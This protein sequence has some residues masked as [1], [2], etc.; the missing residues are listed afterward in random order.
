MIKK[1]LLIFILIIGYG[2]SSQAMLRDLFRT[3]DEISDF[4]TLKKANEDDKRAHRY[5]ILGYDPIVLV[6]DSYNKED[7]VKTLTTQIDLASAKLE[8]YLRSNVGF[9]GCSVAFEKCLLESHVSLFSLLREVAVIRSAHG[10]KYAPNHDD[11]NK[12]M[13]KVIAKAM[14]ESLKKA[15]QLSKV[16]AD[17]KK[18]KEESSKFSRLFLEY[19]G[20]SNQIDAEL[21]KLK[22]DQQKLTAEA[23]DLAKDSDYRATLIGHA[24]DA[25]NALEKSEADLKIK[26]AQQEKVAFE[27]AKA[28]I[29]L[30]ERNEE[31]QEQRDRSCREKLE[32]NGHFEKEIGDVRCLAD[33]KHTQNSTL[34]NSLLKE[35]H[36]LKRELSPLR[37]QVAAQENTLVQK[38]AEIARL[39]KALLNAQ[40]QDGEKK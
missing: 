36:P 20:K 34:I 37:R 25:M 31:L 11:F 39:Q 16:E 5:F 12:L 7:K 8:A 21:K 35:L 22:E 38:D 9:S 1:N 32:L 6:A 29:E 28:A 10:T 17:L 27:V 40:L 23:K 30:E 3:D 14:H 13:A 33:Q 26:V 19:Y 2:N 24:V 15:G 4:G 18:E